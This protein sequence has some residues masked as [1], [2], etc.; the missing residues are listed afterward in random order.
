MMSPEMMKDMT[1]MMKQMNEM[2]RSCHPLG[3]MTVTDHAKMQD[4]AKVMRDMAAQMN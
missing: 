4:M 3:H 1:G 2:M